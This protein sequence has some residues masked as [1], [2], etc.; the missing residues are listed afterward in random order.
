MHQLPYAS[1]IWR[2]APMPG[3]IPLQMALLPK[4]PDGGFRAF[5]R[6]PSGWSRPDIG[7]YAVPEEF[8]VLEGGLSLN[9]KLWQ[10]GELAWIPAWQR[11]HDLQSAPGCLV[12]AWF[13][14]MP[15]WIAGEPGQAAGGPRNRTSLEGRELVRILPGVRETL[16][17]D[18]YTWRVTSA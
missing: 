10:R 3:A 18:D 17:L 16:N 8:L 12:F 9:G 13:G 2:E 14:G 15:R 4:L 5:V 6:F 1:L 11:R 7:H